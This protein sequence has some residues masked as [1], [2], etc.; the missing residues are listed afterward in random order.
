MFKEDQDPKFE[1]I[2]ENKMGII[3]VEADLHEHLM[4][5]RKI[6]KH[7]KLQ[8]ITVAGIEYLVEVKNAD[9]AKVPKNWIKISGTK[10]VSRFHSP[11]IVKL[12]QEREQRKESLGIECDKA[13]SNI[14]KF[15]FFC[16]M[17]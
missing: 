10:T 3:A 4:E 8:Y 1:A 5:I 6:L 11:Q 7:S 2:Q 14:L 16:G 13:Y 9:V 12:L 15:F 17:I